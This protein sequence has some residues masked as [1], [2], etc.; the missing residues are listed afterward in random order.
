MTQNNKNNSRNKANISPITLAAM[1]YIGCY[2][3]NYWVQECML[4]G[5]TQINATAI[6]SI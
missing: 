1:E 4:W 6:L 2:L 5:Y 3:A